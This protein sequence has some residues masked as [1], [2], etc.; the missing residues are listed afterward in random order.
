MRCPQCAA[1]IRNP[2]AF[3]WVLPTIVVAVITYV[4]TATTTNRVAGE[5]YSHMRSNC[6]EL[7]KVS[8]DINADYCM[9]RMTAKSP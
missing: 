3:I 5:V 2:H 7:S 8:H 4:I 1:E 9:K 6:Y